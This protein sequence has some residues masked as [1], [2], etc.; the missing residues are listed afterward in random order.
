MM[1]SQKHNI[2]IV[3]KQKEKYPLQILLGG[4]GKLRWW[5]SRTT[6]GLPCPLNT[7]G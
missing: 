3:P 2:Q 6:L 4:G 1:E 5:H 7:A